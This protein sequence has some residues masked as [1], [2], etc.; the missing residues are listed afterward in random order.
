MIFSI[1]KYNYKCN[2]IYLV[3]WCQS[4][5]T[6][7]IKLYIWQHLYP[8]KC[9]IETRVRSRW[10][11]IANTQAKV[12]DSPSTLQSH[13]GHDLGNRIKKFCSI[14]FL[15]FICENTHKVWYK[16]LW[17]WHV[18]DIWPFDLAPRS[19]VWRQD[20][21]VTCILFCSS[22]PSIWYATWP[23]MKKI[24]DPLGTPVPQSPTPGAWPMRQNKNPVWYVCENKHKIW[25][26][27]FEIDIG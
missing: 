25:Y 12:I 26:K 1:V 27:I 6:S 2:Y 22:S 17:N 21:N 4:N 14:C 10:G 19:P 15:S 11:A 7:C 20:E 23:S 8:F 9:N 24:F 5:F 18:N 3:N 13:P 16:N